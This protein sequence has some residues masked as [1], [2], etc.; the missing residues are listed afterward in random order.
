[1]QIPAST[2]RIQ[3]NREFTFQDLDKILAYLH[4]LGVSAV[5]ASPIVTAVP[6]SMHGYDVT[7]PHEINPEIGS[8]HNSPCWPRGCGNT[9]WC[10]YRILYRIT[11]L[12]TD[13]TSG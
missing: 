6:G 7:D 1:M 5:Y 3:F 13:T 9:T 10:G 4:A 8:W 11:W 12:L 2:Y